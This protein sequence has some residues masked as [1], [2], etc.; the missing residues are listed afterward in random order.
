MTHPKKPQRTIRVLFALSMLKLDYKE[1]ESVC[2]FFYCW[3]GSAGRVRCMCPNQRLGD[4]TAE[5]PLR[6]SDSAR[7]LLKKLYDA[8]M[9]NYHD[10]TA[11][12]T[13]QQG[14]WKTNKVREYRLPLAHVPFCRIV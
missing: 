4:M 10:V 12:K 6:T 2:N 14:S 9:K 11:T 7:P 5:F 3:N 13:I 8:L 1:A